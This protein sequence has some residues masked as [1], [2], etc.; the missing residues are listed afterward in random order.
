MCGLRVLYI[1]TCSCLSVSDGEHTDIS[2]S[3]YEDINT[4]ASALKLYFRLLPIP[5]VTFEVYK[6]L[7]EIISKYCMN[8]I[9]NNEINK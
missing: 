1:K 3:K 9:K 7:I 5:L 2:P 8:K 4:I 6:P